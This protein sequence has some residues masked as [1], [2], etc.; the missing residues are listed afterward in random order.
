MKR[1]RGSEVGVLVFFTF[2]MLLVTFTSCGRKESATRDEFS[3][4]EK[5][6]DL[7]MNAGVEGNLVKS[8]ECISEASKRMMD[9]IVQGR[10]EFMK[11]MV[12]N[13]AVFKNFSVIDKKITGN[14]AIFLTESPDKKVKIAVPFVLERDGWKVDLI[15][16][17]GG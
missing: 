5:T 2:C 6:Y 4:P 14:S 1:V 15:K 8:M 10:E 13:A 7:W 9:Q 3:T 17:F 16:M 11:K 12:V